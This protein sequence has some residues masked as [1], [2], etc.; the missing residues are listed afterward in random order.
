MLRVISAFSGSLAHTGSPLQDKTIVEALQK[1]VSTLSRFAETGE[2]ETTVL[3]FP[4]SSRN[5]RVN[6]WSSHP[7]E[8]RQRQS[9]DS[10]AAS[11]DSDSPASPAPAEDFPGLAERGSIP[12][13]FQSYNACVT[14]TANCSGHGLCED[15]WAARGEDGKKIPAKEGE[16]ACFS[17][18]CKRTRDENNRTTTSWA[19]NMCQKVDV[20]TPFALFVG[21][22]IFMLAI[23][24][25]AIRLL[26]SIGDQPLPGV[27]SAGVMRKPA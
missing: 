23:I 14:T 20:S 15:T 10:A 11:S 25:G 9:N 17:C 6:S 12:N 22:T 24:T 13:C 18:Q 26:Y 1:A 19:G 5:S 7:A 2:M 21:F 3:L 8:L 4:E 27:L 16:L